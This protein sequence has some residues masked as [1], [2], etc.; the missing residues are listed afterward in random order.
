MRS[1]LRRIG[2][3]GVALIVVLPAVASAATLWRRPQRLSSPRTE[4]VAVAADAHGDGVVAWARHDAQGQATIEAAIRSPRAWQPARGLGPA[5]L[6]FGRT[7]AVTMDA[8]GTAYVAWIGRP[9]NALHVARHVRG[10]PWSADDVLGDAAAQPVLAADAAGDAIAAWLHQGDVEVAE[11]PRDGAWSSPALL[12]GAGGGADAV[13]VAMS[14]G[15][16]AV[17]TWRA[18]GIEQ[19]AIGRAGQAFGAAQQLSGGAV[20]L[21]QLASDEAGDFAAVWVTPGSPNVVQ[22]AVRRAG[23]PSFDATADVARRPTVSAP[24]VAVAPG[25]RAAAAW[26]GRYVEFAERSPAGGRW[27]SARRVSGAGDSI[28]SPASVVADAR[29]DLTIGWVG[30]SRSPR[31]IGAAQIADRLHGHALGRPRV[32]SAADEQDV[33]DLALAL[34]ARGAGIAAWRSIRAGTSGAVVRAA[35]RR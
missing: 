5:N 14:A 12:S 8:R 17:V 26:V 32:L 24:D 31:R 13:R 23:A 29:G 10:A 9:D 7:P 25:G 1:C 3:L 11:R 19:A 2:P 22:A 30:S 35:L 20:S 33:T 27:G 28:I 34:G 6:L 15:G 18:R 21:P 4:N 16:D